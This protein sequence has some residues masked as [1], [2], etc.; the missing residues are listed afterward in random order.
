MSKDEQVKAKTREIPLW[1]IVALVALFLWGFFS[2]VE[3]RPLDPLEVLEIIGR[4][5][6]MIKG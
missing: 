3:G 1:A 5:A 6:A 2:L 4:G